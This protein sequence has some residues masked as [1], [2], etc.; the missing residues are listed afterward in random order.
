MVVSRRRQ[1]R[2]CALFYD[3]VV[4]LTFCREIR[5]CHGKSRK[6]HFHCFP[7]HTVSKVMPEH[8][9]GSGV[10]VVRTYIYVVVIVVHSNTFYLYVV[11]SIVDLSR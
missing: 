3:R 11:G 4:V 9:A 8:G 5:L 6:V 1:P 7:Q 10:V 2:Q